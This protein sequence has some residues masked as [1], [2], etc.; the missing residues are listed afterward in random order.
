ML[1]FVTFSSGKNSNE[2]NQ[3]NFRKIILSFTVFFSILCASLAFSQIETMLTPNNGAAGDRFGYS[4][5][6]SE[7]YVVA[8][9]YGNDNENGIDAGAAYVFHLEGSEW[10]QQAKLVASDGAAEDQ[11]GI[12]V[13][14]D[15]DYIVVGAYLDDD[16]GDKSG[17]AYVFKLENGNWIQQAKL[18]ASDAGAEDRFGY[19]VAISGDIIAIG[20]YYNNSK[21]YHAGSAYIFRRGGNTWSQETKLTASD[22]A[23]GDMFG[24]GLD[25]ENNI[26]AIS[27]KYHDA[28]GSSSGAVYAY[29]YSGMVWQERAKVTPLDG[30]AD[31]NFGSSVCLVSHDL[32]I[33]AIK[34]DDQDADAGAVYHYRQSS[35]D[36]NLLNKHIP[37]GLQSVDWFGGSVSADVNHLIVSASMDDDQGDKSGS[38]YIYEKEGYCYYEIAKVTA[39]NTV[40]GDRFGYRVG[41]SGDYVV[42]SAPYTDLNG[43]D[44][45]SIYVYHLI[46]QPE[47][48]SVKDIPNDQGGKVELKWTASW[49]D[50]G[51]NFSYYSVW[52]A[53]DEAPMSSL[54][55]PKNSKNQN[56]TARNYRTITMNGTTQ[57]WGWVANVPGHRHG[58]YVY[59]APTLYDSMA[60]TNGLHYFMVS[61]HLDDEDRFFDSNVASGYSVDNLAPP[62]PTGLTTLF[63][64]NHVDLA[65]E[66]SPAP[67]FS[68]FVIYRNDEV[69]ATTSENSF[70]DSSLDGNELLKYQIQSVDVHGN[71]SG[72]AEEIISTTNTVSRT[73]SEKPDSYRLFSNYPNP[74]NPETE[75]QFDLPEATHVVIKIYNTLGR[76]ITTIVN[77]EYNA[78]TYKARWNGMDQFGNSVSSGVYIYV[79]QANNFTAQKKMT[80]MR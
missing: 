50:L 39:S 27:A 29:T 76:E 70:R 32:I 61:A 44:S 59:T 43:E 47:I 23:E 41:V 22:G 20:A 45:G 21:A 65:W 77:A 79:L 69:L 1:N 35:L 16:G 5:V 58:Q 10:V 19:A 25:L 15:G 54:S 11:F 30:E 63:A 9:A 8:G 36:W 78:G 74:F 66:Q 60:A 17:A 38:C 6:I 13:D 28:M 52:Q 73:D 67:D 2:N 46:E 56:D 62:A 75:I 68:H 51:Q 4:V 37:S 40:T 24:M 80:L 3:T 55:S 71:G 53:L 12:S 48:L 49:Y 31:D 14:M 34:D 26:I 33:G 7:D 64:G 42:A 72:F 18:T 57:T